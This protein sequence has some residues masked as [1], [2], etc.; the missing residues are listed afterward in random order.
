MNASRATATPDRVLEVALQKHRLGK[1]DEALDLLSKLADNNPQKRMQVAVLSGEILFRAGRFEALAA[2]LSTIPDLG[3]DPRIRMLEARYQAR[4]GDPQ[5]ADRILVELLA[6]ESAAYLHRMAAFERVQLL[7]SKG[8]ASEAW[9]VAEA[10][11]RSTT[12]PYDI[13]LLEHSLEVATGWAR[14][15]ALRS[16]VVAPRKCPRTAFI[17]GA[18]RSGTTLLEQ[19]LD[20][21]PL[22]RA[23]GEVPLIPEMSDAIAAAGGGWPYAMFQVDQG[24]VSHWQRRYR[25]EV[26]KANDIRDDQW[27]LDKTVFP[28]LQPLII[29]SVFPGAKVIR[30]TRDPRDT[31]T[32]IFLGN[33]DPS[34]GWTGALDS[35]RRLLEAERKA[36]P[37]LLTALEV[38][39]INVSY[40][41]LVNKPEGELRRILGLLGLP[42][43]EDCLHPEHNSRTAMTLS[44]EQVRRPISSKSIGRWKEYAHRF[45]GAWSRFV[46][47][48]SNAD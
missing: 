25:D 13:R 18:P 46:E 8:C 15:G 43:H 28:M 9:D 29:G 22:I 12:R 37:I 21:H 6:T 2:H 4:R 24:I 34:W 36:V 39:H 42:W 1:T 14:V 7:L 45:D 23:V 33:F 41:S 27:S 10:A 11:H 3:G 5:D 26:R 17:L 35:I 30:I 19:M 44:H 40:E 32:S 16:M 31:A 20:R 48:S 47:A 38:E